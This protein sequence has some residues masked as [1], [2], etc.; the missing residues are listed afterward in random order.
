MNA[1]GS[2]I[3]EVHQSTQRNNSKTIPPRKSIEKQ[4]IAQTPNTG[5]EGLEKFQIMS[6]EIIV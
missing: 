3:N 1:L 5:A 4:P 2:L 6:F